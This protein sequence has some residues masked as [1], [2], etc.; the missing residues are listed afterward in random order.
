MDNF[1]TIT[2]NIGLYYY[3]L[4]KFHK[5]SKPSAYFGAIYLDFNQYFIE[6][7]ITLTDLKIC[8]HSALN[9]S[10][11]FYE[12]TKTITIE[13]LQL[14]MELK[15]DHLPESKRLEANEK[16]KE[17][18]KFLLILT[19]N[20]L[21]I[22]FFVDLPNLS[23]FEI[24]NSVEKKQKDIE[25]V[26]KVS[27]FG[28]DYQPHLNFGEIIE[29]NVYSLKSNSPDLKLIKK[30]KIRYLAYEV[31]IAEKKAIKSKIKTDELK[32]LYNELYISFEKFSLAINFIV[33]HYSR[34]LSDLIKDNL[35]PD[36]I[37]KT[38]QKNIEDINLLYKSY[39]TDT[40]RIMIF[41][42]IDYLS[43]GLSK[44]EL[45]RANSYRKNMG[46]KIFKYPDP[47]NLNP[48]LNK[49]KSEFDEYIN[50]YSQKK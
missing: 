15:D 1:I 50:K 33:N 16:R 38:Y 3:N 34:K 47:I 4:K 24:F 20:V 28:K 32:N 48:N 31:R 18:F 13:N 49:F 6:K 25:E 11:K 36:K 17:E 44:E 9:N 26:L 41:Q 23:A 5:L 40:N 35:E 12:F 46:D 22:M 30:F 27:M 39:E 8:Y 10:Y 29:K 37:L 21:A 14:L 2:N 42:K 43:M 45:R 7:D 19:M